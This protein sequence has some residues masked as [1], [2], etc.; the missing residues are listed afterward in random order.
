MNAPRCALASCLLGLFCIT[1]EVTQ[2]PTVNVDVECKGDDLFINGEYQK[3]C[4]VTYTACVEACRSTPGC[5]VAVFNYPSSDLGDNPVWKDG[6]CW[7]KS[8]C[9]TP[10]PMLGKITT[11]LAPTATATIPKFKPAHPKH[12]YGPVQL[13]ELFFAG[14]TLLRCETEWEDTSPAGEG[15]AQLHDKN[16]NTKWVDFSV[17]PI[18]CEFAAGSDVTRYTVSTANDAVERDPTQWALSH[19]LDGETWSLVHEVTDV[20]PLERNLP[21]AVE[22]PAPFHARFVKIELK[23]LRGEPGAAIPVADLPVGAD[24][25]HGI[26]CEGNDLVYGGT[27]QRAC[28]ISEYLCQMVCS[29]VLH[30]SLY[31]FEE[32]TR[33]C[34]LKT[35]C[36]DRR[37]L[38]GRKA[39]IVRHAV[40]NAHY[41]AS[42]SQFG[43]RDP[44]AQ[45]KDKLSKLAFK[46][47][48]GTN[49]D[50][51]S[52]PELLDTLAEK[53]G[54]DEVAALAQEWLEAQAE[55]ESKEEATAGTSQEGDDTSLPFFATPRPRPA[56][57][58]ATL[59]KEL[60]PQPQ[61]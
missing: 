22:V 61:R 38:F 7:L 1:A 27:V 12:Q 14:A 3:R 32:E 40:S 29:R 35:A 43:Q 39:V 44:L 36:T 8:A 24:V 6:C 31:T 48:T 19:S 58:A 10:R 30:C 17:S 26:S 13:S 11:H 18:I 49:T 56:R 20:L 55:E 28:D 60:Q 15:A 51:Y 57:N 25:F 34:A 45:L 23:T 41:E 50:A 42:A 16:V 33:C 59:E 21:V 9:T 46:G 37:A 52:L 2:E 5:E 4:G 53:Y 47:E 54:E